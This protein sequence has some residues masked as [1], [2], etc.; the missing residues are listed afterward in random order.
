MGDIYQDGTGCKC[1]N[2]SIFAT[3]ISTGDS[4]FMATTMVQK[5]IFLIFS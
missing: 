1:A 3:Q 5:E 2:V 4:V